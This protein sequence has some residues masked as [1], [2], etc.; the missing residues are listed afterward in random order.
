MQEPDVYKYHELLIKRAEL[1]GKI[2]L[3]DVQIKRV[4]IPIR[5]STP[6]KPELRDEAT[7]DLQDEQARLYCELEIV[8]AE[9]EYWDFHK[10]VWKYNTY[11]EGKT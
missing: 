9:I 5:K 2:K 3:L 6:R 7:I 4:E 1:R 8:S 10:D 11:K